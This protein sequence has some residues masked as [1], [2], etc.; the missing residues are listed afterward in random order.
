MTSGD[1]IGPA[2]D[3]GAVQAVKLRDGA[4]SV[5]LW[6]LGAM[7]Q[8]VRIGGG[9]PLLLSPRVPEEATGPLQY[10]GAIVGPVANRLQHGQIPIAGQV[11][12]LSPNEPSGHVVHCGN[13]GLHRR[14]WQVVERSDTHSLLALHVGHGQD[15]LPGNREFRLTYLVEGGTRLSMRLEA[16]TDR[17]TAVNL[18]HHPFWNLD[19]GGVIDDHRLWIDAD[20]VLATDA[21][22]IPTGERQGVAG[23]AFDFREMR[24]IGHATRIDN[25]Y[26]LG[27]NRVALRPVAKLAGA[28]GTRLDISTTEP[29]LQVFDGF[30][31]P[32]GTVPLTNGDVLHPRAGIA[33]EPQFWP[34]APN[35]PGFAPITLT[36]GEVYRQTT[37]YSFH[38]P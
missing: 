16:E 3:G 26:C 1:G 4:L 24:R 2:P 37:Q 34:D 25:N 6:T 13:A 28:S 5:T 7:L 32:E 22:L 31:L 12:S 8:D 9:P 36:P 20:A 21:L 35:Q 33:L 17:E 10:A 11:W 18:A 23:T 38:A 19:G 27:R 30:S 15:G 29:G 14:N